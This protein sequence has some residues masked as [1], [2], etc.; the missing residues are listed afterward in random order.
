MATSK[1]FLN[2]ILEQLSLVEGI[3][4]RAMMGE[5][6]LYC[7]EK[8][9]GGL[10]DNRL[11][12]KITPACEQILPSAPR[13]SPYEGAKPMLL[14]EDTDNRELLVRLFEEMYPEWPA[15]K[16]KKPKKTKS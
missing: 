13:L 15:P 12:L 10:Y 6:V 9:A 3:S 8:V 16:P 2:Y 5:Y 1:D 7:R 14:I 11:M 4:Y